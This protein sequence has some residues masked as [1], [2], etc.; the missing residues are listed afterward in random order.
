[1][2]ILG[3]FYFNAKY[4]CEGFIMQSN[5]SIKKNVSVSN[6]DASFGEGLNLFTQ[7]K[8]LASKYAMER[9]DKCISEAAIFEGKTVIDIGCG[10]GINTLLLA[11]LGAKSVLGIEPASQ[12]IVIAKQKAQEAG[13]PQVT[14]KEVSIFDFE[15]S[16]HQ[17]DIVVLR[18]V[19]HHLNDP[20]WGQ[21]CL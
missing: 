10:D 5:K 13:F 15:E 7:R 16:H 12:A 14:F 19:L 2:L 3:V 18:G 11:K 21:N 9:L 17:F 6:N 4:I 1:M 8:T 20:I